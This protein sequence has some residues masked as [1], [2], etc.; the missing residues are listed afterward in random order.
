ML[1]RRGSDKKNFSF[2]RTKNGQKPRKSSPPVR[3]PYRNQSG[4]VEEVGRDRL[5]FARVKIG[6]IKSPKKASESFFLV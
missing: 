4:V 3:I 5:L 2:A 6:V 1:D